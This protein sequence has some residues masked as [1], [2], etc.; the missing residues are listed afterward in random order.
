VPDRTHFFPLGSIHRAKRIAK[1]VCIIIEN[2]Q[3]W[4]KDVPEEEKMCGDVEGC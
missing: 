1:I 3:K 2:I 4:Q